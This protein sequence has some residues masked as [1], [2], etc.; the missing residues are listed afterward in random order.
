MIDHDVTTERTI[1]G[2]A[3]AAIVCAHY[4]APYFGRTM[5]HAHNRWA[6]IARPFK[7]TASMQWGLHLE[8]GIL[9]WYAN[10]H[11]KGWYL[12]AGVRLEN[13]WRHGSLDA[14]LTSNTEQGP[15]ALA[16]HT[17]VSDAKRAV[18]RRDEWGT[19]DAPLIPL[20]YQVQLGWYGLLAEDAGHD[21]VA[22][23]LAIYDPLADANGGNPGSIRSMA[24]SDLR[25]HAMIWL[26]I[27]EAEVERWRAGITPPW[28]GS[29]AASAYQAVHHAPPTGPKREARMATPEEEDQIERWHNHSIVEKSSGGERKRLGQA[30]TIQADGKRVFLES[31]AYVQAQNTGYGGVTLRGYRFPKEQE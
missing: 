25:P 16:T 29:D 21:V 10:E 23:E 24:W 27:V 11:R 19:D 6:G 3:A 17:I 14:L 12:R 15:H 20:G 4:G 28:D 9:D 18:M 31:G 26:D 1:G 5:W 8:Q 2:T 30:L 13:G 22:C 7:A